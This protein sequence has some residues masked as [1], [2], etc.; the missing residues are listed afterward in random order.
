MIRIFN[1]LSIKNKMITLITTL[2]SLMIAVAGF[3]YMQ[4]QLISVE[5]QSIIKEDIPLTEIT[6]GVT[7]KQLEGAL[8][9][10]KFFRGAGLRETVN[11]SDVARLPTLFTKLSHEIDNEL[12]EAGKILSQAS[13][14]ASSESLANEVQAL[15]QTLEVLQREH[16]EYGKL[17]EVL[18]KDIENN[19]IQAAENQLPRLEQQQ[20]ALNHHLEAF[21][22]SVEKLTEHAL[23]QTEEHEEA[24]VQGMAMIGIAGVIIGILLGALFTRTLTKS[25]RL[26]VEA[27]D[28]MADGNFNIT[29]HSVSK[30]ETGLLLNAMNRMARKLEQTISQ[31]LSS[32][33]QIA[34]VAEEMAAATEQTNQAI[35]S[36]QMDTEHVVSSITEMAT[37]VQQIAGNASTASSATS[38]A[39]NEVEN[40]SLVVSSNQREIDNLVEQIQTAAGEVQSVSKESNAISEFVTSI[41]EIAEQTNLLALNAAIEAARAGEQGRGFAVVADEVRNL[42][43]RTQSVT[44]E[45]HQ[46]IEVLQSKASNA[47]D[48]IKQSSNMVNESA[49][50]AETASQSLAVINQSVDE[51]SGMSMEIASIC[52]QQSAAAEEISQSMSNISHSGREV[53]DGSAN[54]ARSS[55]ELAI[56]AVELRKLM[57]QFKVN[58]T[59]S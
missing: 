6:T 14:A 26:A 48:V 47:V 18:I 59:A 46:L 3:G 32:S 57:L 53:L 54:T 55:E 9:L 4:M 38:N 16:I 29:L 19:S 1:N 24:A 30:D 23:I 20:K 25:L 34:T 52:E 28:K 13:T 56:L 36:Q 43:Q 10:E 51:I 11:S 7:T 44:T 31:V 17:A 12:A 37:T 45:I 27:S 35:N 5:L 2:L 33:G 15:Q 22:V 40:G 58:S 49:K 42:A 50:N 21:L 39:S 8:I 41:T